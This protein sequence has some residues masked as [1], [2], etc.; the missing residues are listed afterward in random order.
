MSVGNVARYF[1][2][3]KDRKMAT[4]STK[5][6]SKKARKARKQYSNDDAGKSEKFRDF[7]N[8]R[9]EKV[10]KALKQIAN[11]SGSSYKSTDSEIKKMFEAIRDKVDIAEARFQKGSK[12]E[13][14]EKLF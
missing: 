13:V 12:A 11:L 2:N 10:A 9:F 8:V 3:W 5:K 6:V 4:P 14:T 7:A 1:D